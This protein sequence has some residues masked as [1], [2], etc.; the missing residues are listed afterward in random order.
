MWF[1]T[2]YIFC[3]QVHVS[4]Y[5]ETMKCT[6]AGTQRFRQ[7]AAL[8]A[9]VRK[10]EGDLEHRG[11]KISDLKKYAQKLK[12]RIQVKQGLFLPPKCENNHGR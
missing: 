2:S 10:L 7:E 5:T 4:D 6:S 3:S 9:Q 1:Y 8:Q 12:D 11:R